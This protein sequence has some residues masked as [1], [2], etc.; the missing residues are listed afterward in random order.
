MNLNTETKNVTQ[1]NEISNIQKFIN[2]ITGK[3]CK[4]LLGIIFIIIFVLFVD[5]FVRTIGYN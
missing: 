4:I 1:L 5:W 3:H 2:C